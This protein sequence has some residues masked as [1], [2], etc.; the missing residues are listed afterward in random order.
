EVG[1]AVEEGDQRAAA[2][3]PD[4]GLARGVAAAHDRHA[5]A[6]AELRLGGARGVEGGQPLELG[7]PLDREPAVLRAGGEQDGAGGDLAVVLEADEMA[8]GSRLEG[9][10]A[11]RRGAARVELARLRDGAARELGAGDPRGKPEVVLDPARRPGLAAERGA[12]D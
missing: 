4:G 3:K 6:G 12:L 10:R 8:S 7:E 9:E 2:G 1:A 5:R 11:V